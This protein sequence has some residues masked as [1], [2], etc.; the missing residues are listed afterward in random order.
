MRHPIIQSRTD[1]IISSFRSFLSDFTGCPESG[2]FSPASLLYPILRRE[3]VEGRRGF[4]FY[5]TFGE[6][7]LKRRNFRR[8]MR[9]KGGKTG[10]KFLGLLTGPPKVCDER[11][12]RRAGTGRKKAVCQIRKQPLKSSFRHTKAAF[13]GARY[14]QM[15]MSQYGAVLLIKSSKDVF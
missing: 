7:L 13:R 8:K 9:G 12:R 11:T 6:I 14:G 4:R 2:T 3:F 15:K 1:F 5:T 10:G